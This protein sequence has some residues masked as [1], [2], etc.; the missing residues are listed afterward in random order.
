MQIINKQ[1]HLASATG[2][3]SSNFPKSQIYAFSVEGKHHESSF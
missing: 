3:H 1:I 2:T